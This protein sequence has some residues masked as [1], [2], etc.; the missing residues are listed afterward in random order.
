VPGSVADSAAACLSRHAPIMRR[1]A[2]PISLRGKSVDSRPIATD[3]AVMENVTDGANAATTTGHATGARHRTAAE[4]EVGLERVRRSPRGVG[5][6]D[7]VVRR[8]AVDAREILAAGELDLAE[9]L[10][11]DTWRLRG[12]KRTDDGSADP[13]MQLNVIN[14][15]F[16]ALVAGPEHERWALAGDQLY[17]DLD[18]GHEALPAGT[19][20]AI[21]DVAV[22]EVTERPHTGC[23]KFAARFGR[24][25]HKL[26]WSEQG[27][28]WRLRG[29]NAR[30]VVPGTV[31]PADAVRVVP[32]GAA[33]RSGSASVPSA[34]L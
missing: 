2:C 4:L 6:L 3:T 22:I 17:V 11:G 9:G 30:V 34:E 31:R 29:L 21:G 14:S 32:R 13:D 33:D 5:T 25:A 7:L 23:A 20:L 24:D 18:V 12:S 1:A 27:R 19:R 8:P 10:V 16:A 26:V 15:R 28:H